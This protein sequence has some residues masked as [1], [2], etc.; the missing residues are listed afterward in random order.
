MSPFRTNGSADQPQG[1][2]PA[3]PQRSEFCGP[4]WHIEGAKIIEPSKTPPVIRTGAHAWA[5]R[6]WSIHGSHGFRL[7]GVYKLTILRLRVLPGFPALL[8]LRELLL[9]LRPRV[10]QN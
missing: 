1:T 5:E 3:K 8:L 10:A 2:L 4:Y 9:A 7:L 6:L